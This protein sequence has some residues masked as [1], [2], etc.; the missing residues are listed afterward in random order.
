MKKLSIFV[1]ITFFCLLQI[2]GI[3]AS[4]AA[5]DQ[6]SSSWPLPQQI[7][8]Y[9]PE[10]WPPILL[11]DSYGTV[12]AFSSQWLSGKTVREIMYNKWNLG[13]GWTAPTDILISVLLL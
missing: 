10:T 3:T 13:Q 1:I 2:E 6:I 5:L 12:H 9:D 8:G 7:P 11:V 4:A